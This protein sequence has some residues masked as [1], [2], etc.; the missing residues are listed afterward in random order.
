MT[1]D[2]GARLEVVPMWSLDDIVRHAGTADAIM[3]GAVEPIDRAALQAMTKCRVVVRRG[4]GMNNVDLAAATELGIPVAYVPHASI[5]E[6]SDHALALLLA[7]ERRVVSLDALVHAGR[8]TKATADIAAARSG[9]RRL[10]ELTLGVVGFGL[11]GR[12]LARK[13]TPLFSRMVVF[14]PYAND[15]TSVEF[16]DFATLLG[17]ADLI[18][19]HAPLTED[20]RH[21]FDDAAFQQM[22]PGCT[23][24]NTS[25]GALVDTEALVRA[26]RSG[27]VRGAGLDVTEEEPIGAD[28]VVL[29][30][31]NVILTGHS[32]ASS[33][34]STAEMRATAVTAVADAFQG[35]RPRF[36]ANAAV[37]D[38]PTSRL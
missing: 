30:F 11:I 18:S 28:S 25:R 9:M 12:E 24:V 23:L 34:S 5:Q 2:L 33:D 26:L 20:T 36:V 37:F 38:Q 6:V 15:A 7:L 10:A 31:D 1:T 17:Q 3:V 14:D 4:A 8:W 22:K 32:A 29:S 13:A 27:T 19:I 21:M 35:R 16:V